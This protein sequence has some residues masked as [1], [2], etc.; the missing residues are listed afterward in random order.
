M[1]SAEDSSEE[2]ETETDEEE[3]EET[4]EEDVSEEDTSE[5]DVSEE[6]TFEKEKT[7]IAED[8]LSAEETAADLETSADESESG[9]SE[10]EITESGAETAEDTEETE[11]TEEKQE[12]EKVIEEAEE[13]EAEDNDTEAS[14]TESSEDTA[15]TDAARAE[16]AG[17]AEDADAEKMG[18]VIQAELAEDD[19]EDEDEVLEAGGEDLGALFGLGFLQ[20]QVSETEEVEESE[21]IEEAEETEE[22]EETEE[23]GETEEAEESEEGEETEETEETA[24]TDDDDDEIIGEKQELDAMFAG[25]LDDT[26]DDDEI[27]DDIAAPET[28]MDIFGTVAGVKSI[29]NQLTETFTKFE[30]NA[31]SNMDLLAPYDINFI[32]TGDDMSVK[33]QIAIG[34][35]KALNTYGICDKSKL[36][37][38][39][40]DDLNGRDFSAI[41]SKISGGCLIIED[42]DRLDEKAVL[43]I[44]AYVQKKN[45]DVAIVLEGEEKQIRG[46]LATYPAIRSKFLNIIHIGKYNEDELVQ[47]AA[48][49]AKK[50][51]YEIAAPAKKKLKTIIS[52]RMRDNYSV[53]YEDIMA[54]IEEAISSLEKRNMKNL[55]MTVLDNKYEEAAMFLLLPE[56]FDNINIPN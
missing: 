7:D 19:D 24:E 21:E 29:K 23:A 38:A 42:A 30:D 33:S 51:G 16:T 4:S 15:G 26:A 35:A 50:K 48:G 22:T 8:T 34:I 6:D 1:A 13:S 44:S 32:V 43:T 39:T 9:E 55:F 18:E 28:V 14:G 36:V 31:L 46:L 17:G 54:I 12:T 47:L 20:D 11:F 49:Y 56:D 2:E 5:E 37:R 3:S 45:Q 53:N 40:A 41:F 25:M 52:D 10:D 27:S